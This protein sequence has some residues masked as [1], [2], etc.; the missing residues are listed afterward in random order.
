M[1]GTWQ[2]FTA[3]SS[4]S[5]DTM[6]L[7][8][9]GSVLVHNAD[10]TSGKGTGGNDWYRL[11]PDD[12]GS[13]RNG[14]W[15]GA[16]RMT[17]ERQFFATGV[18]TDG[19]VFAVG[20]EY[21][22][23]FAQDGCALGEIFDPT[24]NAWSA[25]NKPSPT[26]DHIAGDCSAIVL[27]DGR[28]LFAGNPSGSRTAIW[29]PV[30][31]TWVEAGVGFN[32]T[33]TQTKKGV[34]NEET[35]TLL[36][37]GNILAVQITGT[38]ATRN[39][40]QYVPSTDKWVSAGKT[41]Q[42]LV[43]GSIKG[44]TSNEI[45]P[46]MLLPSGKVIAFGGNGHTE[47][48]TPDADPTKAGTWVAGPDMPADAPNTLS[49]AGLLSILD[50][51]AVL[52]PGGKVICM[53]GVTR[54][55]T[56]TTG[57]ISYWSG[58][59]QFL[60][61]D[62]ASA[63]TT[64]PTMTNQPSNN[65]GDTWTA[66]LL[67]L[68]N[69]HVLYAA[70]QNTMAEYTPDTAE[71]TPN[72]SWRPSIT[73]CPDALIKGHTYTIK[74][75]LFNGMSHANS[76]GDD[77]QAATNYPI[78][79]LTNSAGKVKY[80]RSHDFSGMGVATGAAAATTKI[81]VPAD[82]ANGQ[83]DL[84]VIANGIASAAKSVQVGTHD[85][86]FIVDRSTVSKGEVDALISLRGAPA[87]LEPAFYVVV[88]GFTPNELGGL[89]PNNLA[90]PPVVPT[91][92]ASVAG[93]TAQLDGK[94]LPEDPALHPDVPQRITFPFKVSFANSN[95]FAFTGPTELVTLN[96]SLVR[97]NAT[98]SNF[99][100]MLLLQNPNP[101]ILHGDQVAGFPWYLSVDLRVMQLKENDK[102]FGATVGTGAADTVATTFITSVI[103]NLNTHV[104]TLTPDFDALPQ[105]EELSTLALAPTDSAGKAVYNFALAR[106]RFRD[107]NQDAHNVR[108]FFRMY[109][110]QQTD[111]TFN[112]VTTYRSASTGGKVVPLL[113]VVGDEIATIPFFA[114][115]RVDSSTV[116]MRTQTDP[117]N[118]HA[119]IA[120]DTL[121]GEV[122]TYFG[123]WLDINQPS[124]VRFPARLLGSTPANL[125]DGPF[126]GTG[127]LLPIQQL[128]RSAHQCLV[129]EISMDGLTI[130]GTADPSISDKLAQ[131]N[132]TFVNVPN[133]GIDTSR[134]A[135]QTFE[136]KP[137]PALLLDGKPDEL[138]IDWGETPDGS[139][140]SI[141]FPGADAAESIAWAESM[142]V[143]HRLTMTDAH[144]ITC[145]VGGVTYLPVA[146]G[147]G[148][149]FA[150]LLSVHLPLGIRKGQEFTVVV[151]QITGVSTQLRDVRG[152]QAV[153]LALEAAATHEGD[154][155][156]GGFA[157]RRSLGVFALTIP[158]S[159]KAALLGDE[160][161]ALSIFRKIEAG[162]PIESRWYPVFRRYI[163]QLV[164]RVSGMGGDP[165]KVG[166]T[167]DGDWQHT[168]GHGGD[169]GR[170]RDTGGR[171]EH[172]QD[173]D[174]LDR[175]VGK[176]SGLVYDRFGDFSGFH[177]ETGTC[178]HR[179]VC[180]TEQRVEQLARTA[181]QQRSTVHV[182]VKGSHGC[183]L[184]R[185][186]VGDSD[187]CDSD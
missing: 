66:S 121:G 73:A 101:Y 114:S 167:D 47:I 123:C 72:A 18:L 48:Y 51:G 185:L 34:N 31:D 6:L 122:D 91:V 53:G 28:V 1:A 152:G 83:W 102:R 80:L 93:I 125:P 169:G 68:P 10:G 124:R 109:P 17:T 57:A 63:T 58:P 49:P 69:G 90:N 119:T 131:R 5:A 95:M 37:N 13:Y 97:P 166:P 184:V 118:A 138:M 60:L 67:L 23:G 150:G 106:V 20:G 61:Y 86:F 32:P 180:S 41:T 15:S 30:T 156:K 71:L 133:P 153:P 96:A 21:A 163:D 139:T 52:L 127:P 143:T 146:Q 165:N 85:C 89:T 120:H 187:C 74:G 179:E 38:T 40:E 8:T 29:D 173:C 24:T 175:L 43:V 135:P 147:T 174:D 159:T 151:R 12:S 108:L 4:V 16:L 126:Q 132:L 130:P 50:A 115:K 140:A 92:T 137:S 144:T 110:A 177:L 76:Y 136:V 141:Y 99:G 164:G 176:V 87:V 107:L 3:P 14:K 88:E 117:V 36:P 111:S 7:L 54:K 113:G 55:E 170:D 22:T 64:L 129:A 145:P 84:V 186:T 142:Y 70:E 26:Y 157:W 168:G 134:I 42:N 11:T 181:W 148:A 44:V 65:S 75:T 182:V 35:W 78:V 82:L 162:I 39:A 33:G 45:G 178:E 160:M 59:T 56:S 172:D 25:M 149:N 103:N 27:A 19:R 77:R 98:V 104:A 81:D 158:V 128:V 155:G 2:T 183:C 154:A 105:A 94:V 62:P 46:A 116:S 100:L 171:D 9:D 79:R 112:S 161:R